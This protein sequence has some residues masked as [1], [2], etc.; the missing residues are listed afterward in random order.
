M[1]DDLSSIEGL[2]DKHRRVLARHHVTDLRG[3][4][5]S[6]RRMIHR[7]M[8][9]LRPR[10]TLELI[11]RWQDDARG[12]LDLAVTDVSDWHTAASFVVIFSQRQHEGTWERRV[13]MERTEV[14]P[15]RR[16]QVRSG[17]DCA[18][19][20]T[21]MTAQLTQPDRA[22]VRSSGEPRRPRRSRSRPC[23][24]G[25]RFPLG[26]GP[27][28]DQGRSRSGPSSASTAPRSSTRLGA[29]TW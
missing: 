21:W 2:A 13:E 11:S 16:P 25:L 22:A 24:L 4:V 12:Q 14:E 18:P 8:A 20:C 9:N 17:W 3:L 10:P 1:P 26:P 29:R 19:V 7:A 27:P 28:P 15:E 5:Q 6:D 23:R